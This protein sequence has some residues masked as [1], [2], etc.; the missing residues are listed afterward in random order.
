MASPEE[1]VHLEVPLAKGVHL[2]VPLAKG[3]SRVVVLPR[4]GFRE[5]VIRE[6]V[7]LE[8]PLLEVA[9]DLELPRAVALGPVATRR[10]L[11]QNLVQPLLL[12]LAPLSR[13]E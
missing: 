9:R 1:G 12:S 2:K 7:V 10:I 4:V 8:D 13:A 11:A 3:V 6:V 5:V